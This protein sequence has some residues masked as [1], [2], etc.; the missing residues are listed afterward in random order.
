MLS[1]RKVNLLKKILAVLKASHMGNW[2]L[3]ESTNLVW[4]PLL[5]KFANLRWA[6]Y[7]GGIIELPQFKMYV[8]P[9]EAAVSKSIFLHKEWEPFESN[10]FCHSISEGDIVLDIG[11]HIGWYSL[12]ASAR[13]GKRGKVYAF[14]PE[15]KS[16]SIL[17]RNIKLNYITNIVLVNKALSNS[18]GSEQ[19][20]VNLYKK[21]PSNYQMWPIDNEDSISIDVIT[22]DEYL[23]DKHVDVIKIDAEGYEV[24]VFRGA[25]KVLSENPELVIFS[26][27]WPEG[28]RG[29]GDSP[30]EYI[31]II[32]KHGFCIQKIENGELEKISYREALNLREVANFLLSKHPMQ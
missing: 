4:L 28:L 8:D 12:L 23:K 7:D 31:D 32:S 1:F 27:Y 25:E 26:E 3:I 24:K 15:P 9:M 2:H 17:S 10:L 21:G 13:V 14:E 20:F 19:L 29:A 22:L 30:E 16:F 18:S 6:K 5:R 11:A